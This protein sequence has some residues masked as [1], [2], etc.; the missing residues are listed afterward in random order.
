MQKKKMIGYHLQQSSHCIFVLTAKTADMLCG[1]GQRSG[2]ASSQ[3]RRTSAA[4][5]L[6]EKTSLQRRTTSTHL[7]DFK[8]TYISSSAS[9]WLWW[10]NSWF[11]TPTWPSY[12]RLYFGIPATISDSIPQWSD[13]RRILKN[14]ENQKYI[15]FFFFFLNKLIL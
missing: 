8:N 13:P 11:F 1:A 2:P 4:H 6:H 3:C 10:T 7:H 12:L 15:C 14:P 5:S 9:E